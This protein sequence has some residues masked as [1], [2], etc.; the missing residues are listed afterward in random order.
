MA[1]KVVTRP[2]WPERTE[3]K[4]VRRPFWPERAN[5]ESSE[6]VDKFLD[7]PLTFLGPS[8]VKK[9]Q[10]VKVK[11]RPGYQGTRYIE[12]VLQKN[13]ISP[14]LYSI[15]ADSIHT[16]VINDTLVSG[17]YAIEEMPGYL[18]TIMGSESV[19]GDT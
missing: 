10:T 7:S 14:D 6:P 1:W 11:A 17:A 4:V 15:G 18:G 16:M 3:W 5:D 13:P 19:Q 2:F 8:D 9:S 12:F